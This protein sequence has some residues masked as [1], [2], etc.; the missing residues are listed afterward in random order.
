[1]L[2]G[3]RVHAF[4]DKV[5]ADL[6]TG[7][8][9]RRDIVPWV[10]ALAAPA[11]LGVATGLGGCLAIDGSVGGEYLDK[12]SVQTGVADG[13]NA[14]LCVELGFTPECDLCTELGWYDDGVCDDFCTEP[15]ID[16]LGT[17]PSVLYAAPME[18][19]SDGIDNDFDG[20]IDCEDQDCLSD[21]ACGI[22]PTNL[23]GV[24][25]EDCSD[26]WDNDFDGRTDC[27]DDDCAGDM[28]CGGSRYG[29]PFE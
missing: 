13:M 27:D 9:P 4:L 15:D 7:R 1:M 20:D 12:A 26:G 5:I 24:P 17:G 19:C 10:R 18:N 2:S 23:Y 14:R 11:A 22:G 8:T 21:P 3:K 29:A 28:S 16:C 6:D 25:F